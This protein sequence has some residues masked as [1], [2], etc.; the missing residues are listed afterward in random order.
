MTDTALIARWYELS[1]RY[2]TLNA[3]LKPG[4]LGALD[5]ISSLIGMG[6]EMSVIES[7]LYERGYEYDGEWKQAV[8]D[9]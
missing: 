3:Q 7:Q 1:E 4:T 6:R 5:V 8:T 9:E 2:D